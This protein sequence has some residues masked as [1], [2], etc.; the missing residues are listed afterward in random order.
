MIDFPD[1]LA[2][3]HTN[4]AKAVDLIISMLVDSDS[5]NQILQMA[6]R[7]HAQGFR[8][9]ED[10]MFTWEPRERRLNVYEEIADAIVYLTSGKI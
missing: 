8:E 7:R 4:K 6:S 3:F 10:R 9:Y 5:R 1:Q 2:A